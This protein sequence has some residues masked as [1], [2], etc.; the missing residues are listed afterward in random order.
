MDLKSTLYITVLILHVTI[1]Q[2][3]LV[4]TL[5]IIEPMETVT[6]HCYSDQ[7]GTVWHCNYIPEVIPFGYSNVYINTSELDI[8]CNATSFQSISWEQV[9]TL[10]LE[11]TDWSTNVHVNLHQN[12]FQNLKQLKYLNINVGVNLNLSP[13]AFNGLFTVTKL[14]LANCVRLVWKDLIEA[15]DGQYKVPN[16]TALDFSYIN[17]IAGSVKIDE[18]SI[19]IISTRNITWLNFSGMQ[20]S[21]LN[22]TALIKSMR[23]LSYL[24]LSSMNLND[25]IYDGTAEDIK[26]IKTLDVS[27][28]I[29]PKSATIFG[30][31]R[32]YNLD[33]TYSNTHKGVENLFII[34]NILASGTLN[35]ATYKLYNC[36]FIVDTYISIATQTLDLSNNNFIH[37]DLEISGDMEYR[38]ISIKH[39]N[40]SKNKMDFLHPTILTLVP[41]VETINL[42]DNDLHTM[43]QKDHDKFE[44]LLKSAT[45]LKSIDLSKNGLQG[46]P[47]NQ[48]IYNIDI[49]E[50][51]LSY[52]LIQQVTWKMDHLLK[53]SR[54]DLSN[55]K[56]TNLDWTSLK[57]LNRLA[58][59]LP[60]SHKFKLILENNQISC[61]ECESKPFIKWLTETKAVNLSTQLLTCIDENDKHV[62]INESAVKQLESIC[63]QKTKIILCTVT[64]G[65]I[66][67]CSLILIAIFVR[68]QCLHTERVKKHQLLAN[69]REGQG[70]Y[71]FVLML[72]YNN[73]DEH[74]IQHH[75][76]EQ[77]NHNLQTMIGVDRDLILTGDEHFRPGFMVHNEIASSLD[78][79]AMVILLVTNEFCTSGFCLSE[80]DQ[81]WIQ[82]KPMIFM[83]KGDVDENLMS[84]L[85]KTIYNK[86]VR[87][88]WKMEN[89]EY[90]LKTSWENVCKA[91]LELLVK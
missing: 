47:A 27:N 12:C 85:M 13:E 21:F 9:V 24:N 26:I 43:L 77:L 49:E 67:L 86:N 14:S 68:Q 16:L 38:N 23:F 17:V 84:P 35:T 54:L 78:R 5:Q 79:V 60:E 56:I 36:K 42:S 44:I 52:N 65:T 34:K 73:Q 37:A 22:A 58:S 71:E 29:L 75:V 33:I 4:Q 15:L 74:F 51:L 48:F 45:S 82:R 57:N 70:Q 55:N 76:Q 91:I 18:E 8:Q 64:L 81:A 6:G 66:C 59:N 50:I 31:I 69:L 1:Y 72:S 19:D 83:F 10:T 63:F 3:T 25:F 61:S 7:N 20:V 32:I 11:N 80:L 90:V 62:K 28:M 41:H 2:T 88:L 53:L 40:L 87:I 46:V 89:G 30:P 39:V